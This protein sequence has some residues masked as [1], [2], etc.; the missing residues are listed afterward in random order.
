M[1]VVGREVEV[2]RDVAVGL[3]DG[4]DGDEVR[5]RDG[6]DDGTKDGPDV[7]DRERAM[8]GTTVEVITVGVMLR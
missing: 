6:N 4:P 5:D 7:G 2:S 3:R 8:V 1:I